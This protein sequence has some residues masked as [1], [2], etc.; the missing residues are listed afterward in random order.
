[1]MLSDGKLLRQPQGRQ[2]KARQAHQHRSTDPRTGR[3]YRIVRPRQQLGSP[4]HALRK[5]TLDNLALL[6]ASLLPFKAE[7]QAIANQ[8]A[9]GTILVVLPTN[10]SLPRRTLER[11]VTRMQARGQSVRTVMKSQLQ[12]QI[13]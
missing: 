9:P 11:V 10:D 13:L 7:Y 6:P 2:P 5:A 3:L 4:P 8:Q 1:M 12:G